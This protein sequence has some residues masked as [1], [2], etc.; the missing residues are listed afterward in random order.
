MY[1]HLF[2]KVCTCHRLQATCHVIHL[3]ARQVIACVTNNIITLTKQHAYVRFMA[4][5]VLVSDTISGC[6]EN[7]LDLLSASA[8]SHTWVFLA[9]SRQFCGT[10]S[11]RPLLT[12]ESD[13]CLDVICRSFMYFIYNC[14]ILSMSI[15][16]AAGSPRSSMAT[17]PQPPRYAI[18]KEQTDSQLRK[19]ELE[20]SS[21]KLENKSL[22]DKYNRAQC[23]YSNSY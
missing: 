22:K 3:L 8:Y 6:H 2:M 11:V 19:L 21:L 1:C 4:H 13:H 10:T 15:Q 17:S 12:S 18:E 16:I 7:D 14:L 9:S 5:L 23:K 20:N